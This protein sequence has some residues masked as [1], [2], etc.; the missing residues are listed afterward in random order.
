M[1][2]KQLDLRFWG[3]RRS[4]TLQVINGL[5]HFLWEGDSQLHLP[6]CGLNPPVKRGGGGAT[7]FLI[8]CYLNFPTPHK[9][10]GDLFHFVYIHF[11]VFFNSNC[12]LATL[13][14]TLYREN[15]FKSNNLVKRKKKKS[16]SRFYICRN[17]GLTK[18]L[19]LEN[20]SQSSSIFLLSI[21][22]IV[23][24]ERL[25]LFHP[26]FIFFYPY[27]CCRCTQLQRLSRSHLVAVC[28]LEKLRVLR[29]N[30]TWAGK[31]QKGGKKKRK[32]KAQK[33]QREK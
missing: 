22:A 9:W 4:S 15:R 6:E 5:N 26:P 32:K 14:S 13:R 25:C 12:H 21:Y 24:L 3:K 29:I 19:A 7:A 30:C 27:S 10:K 2:L 33:G 16:S 31:T 8:S 11:R 17:D 1:S 18:Q 20:A 23:I 28:W